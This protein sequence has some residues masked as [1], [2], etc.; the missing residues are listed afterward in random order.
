MSEVPRCPNC[1][2]ELDR[3][4]MARSVKLE[5]TG[6]KWVETEVFS[7]SISCPNCDTELDR[8][9]F[10]DAEVDIPTSV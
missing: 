10:D 2:Y 3:I 1:G 8:E 9:I 5:W 4:Y 6:D 7:E